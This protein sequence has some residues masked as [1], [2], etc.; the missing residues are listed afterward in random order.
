MPFPLTRG[1]NKRG[2]GVG[3]LLVTSLLGLGSCQHLNFG[4]GEV[5][6]EKP[7]AC[8]GEIKDLKEKKF[9]LEGPLE[10]RIHTTFTGVLELERTAGKLDDRLAEVCESIARSLGVEKPEVKAQSSLG[11]RTELAC[12]KAIEKLTSIKQKNSVTLSI[13]A[14]EFECGVRPDDFATC[15]KQCD[16]NLPPGNTDLGC[17]EGKLRGRCTGKCTGECGQINTNSC[18]ATC[19]GECNGSC[20]KGFYGHC[21]GKCIG[22]CDMANVNGKCSGMCDGKCLSDARGTCEGTC[23]GKC[24]GNCTKD[25][26]KASCDGTCTGQCDAT[27]AAPVCSETLPPPEM[28]PE[29]VA[30][31]SAAMT[32]KLQCTT[33]HVGIALVRADKE[34]EG[35]RVQNALAGRLKDVLEIGD[36]MKVPLESAAAK[37]TESLD[38]LKDDL[39]DDAAA[40]K[41]VH[42]CLSEAI[43]KKD[44]AEA[45]FAKLSKV[46]AELFDA[47]RN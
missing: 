17:E 18:A 45:A 11:M 39:A 9:G 6:P 47:A 40:E 13:D 37:M 21:G 8:L 33:A 15:A 1:H 12:K 4:R 16:V 35:K 5:A 3:A 32:S 28:T 43:N 29:C 7:P 24:T 42:T 38:A 23:K 19:E 27:M 36:G 22:T 31:C 14:K 34:A 20:T 41:K 10:E 25:V 46:S 30:M 2:V 26:K 44:A